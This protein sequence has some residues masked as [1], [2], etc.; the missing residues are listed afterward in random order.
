MNPEQLITPPIVGNYGSYYRY[1]VNSDGTLGV[2]YYSSDGT[3]INNTVFQQMNPQISTQELE[4]VNGATPLT[5]LSGAYVGGAIQ[6]N[7]G[8]FDLSGGQVAGVSTDSRVFGN[9][10]QVDGAGAQWANT[11]LTNQLVDL[12]T[13]SGRQAYFAE[14]NQLADQQ[15]N[16]QISALER[17]YNLTREQAEQSF[18]DNLRQLGVNENEINNA[19]ESGRRSYERQRV[20]VGNQLTSN[21]MARQSRFSAASP[22][23][24]Q[25]AQI[26]SGVYDREQGA[27][28]IGDINL[29]EN[30]FS[31]RNQAGL[32]DIARQRQD[33]QNRYNVFQ[34]NANQNFQANAANIRNT[35]NAQRSQLGANF[36]NVNAA[37][38]LSPFQYQTN[39]FAPVQASQVSTGNL[40]AYS[41]FSGISAN[42]QQ[43]VPQIRNFFSDQSVTGAPQ[44][45]AYL[46]GQVS[47]KEQDFFSQ[48][49]QGKTK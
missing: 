20:G 17:Q 32:A 47:P 11:P 43:Q 10:S 41:G 49:L 29:A 40:P 37:Q 22:S 48:Y 35:I 14:Q 5:N 8:T 39:A 45:A 23:A 26:D 42:A 30:E 3:P 6:T 46:G 21:E 16:D 38:G 31:Q 24:F 12:N 34:E 15:I 44:L 2:N 36:A 7:K 25:S 13:D 9:A 4:A 19:I 27:R 1:K 33:I 18:T 28:A